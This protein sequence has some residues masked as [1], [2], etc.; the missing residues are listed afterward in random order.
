MNI[1]ICRYYFDDSSN[2]YE[3]VRSDDWNGVYIHEAVLNYCE[4]LNEYNP[5]KNNI[6]IM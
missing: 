3:Y 6:V 1:L 2:E 5:I 4:P